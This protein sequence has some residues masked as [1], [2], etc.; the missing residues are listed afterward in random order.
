MMPGCLI[1]KHLLELNSLYN[2][3]FIYIMPAVYFW[4]F[5]QI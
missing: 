4:P 1:I 2:Q 3:A 5:R